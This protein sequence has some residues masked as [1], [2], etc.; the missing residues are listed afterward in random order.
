MIIVRS[1][2]GLIIYDRGCRLHTYM[3]RREPAW[4][5]HCK[6]RVDC[7]HISNHVACSEGYNPYI[8]R[9]TKYASSAQNYAFANTQV[10]E[11]CNSAL[12]FLRTP[13]SFMKAE[14][15]MQYT[16][17]FLGLRNMRKKQLV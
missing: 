1:G 11:Q 14:N 4:A 15:F 2:P 10:A 17:T 12:K 8:Y 13:G 16:R 6:L 5:Q 3:L 7:S 9:S